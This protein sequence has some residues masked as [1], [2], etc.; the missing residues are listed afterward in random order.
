[1]TAGDGSIRSILDKPLEELT[2]EDISQ[3]TREDCRRY[4]KEKGMRRPSWNKYQAIQQVLSLKGLLEGKPCDDNSDVFSHRSPITVIPNVGSMREKEK[5]VNIADP[6]ISGSHQP[7]FRREIHETTRERA[8]PASDWPPSQEPVSQMTIFYAGA[9]NVYNDI[10]EDKVQ[11]IIYLAGKSDSLQ[12]T[13]VIRTGPDQCIASAASPSL[14]DLHSRRIHPTSN[15]TTSQSL[16]VATS[17]PVGPHSEVPKTRKTSVQRFL[18][19]RKDRGRLKGT[20]ASG[21]SSKRGSSCLELYATSRLKSEGVA[22]TT[23]QSNMNNVVVSPS[24]PRMPLNPGSCSW[25]EN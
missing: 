24:N 25:V 6:E 16:R 10:P 15:I 13:N 7:N 23:T 17:L 20:L 22:T 2:E 11:A 4:L 19:K 1:M 5:A 14:N 3:L 8:L 18:E 9:V 21:G 12:Q